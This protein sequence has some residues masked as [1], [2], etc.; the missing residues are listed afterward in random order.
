MGQRLPHEAVCN[1]ICLT[2]YGAPHDFALDQSD[3]IGRH[4]PASSWSW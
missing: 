1:G 4:W 2:G 3:R